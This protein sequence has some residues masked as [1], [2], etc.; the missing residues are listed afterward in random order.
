MNRPFYTQSGMTLIEILIT[1]LVMSVGLLGLAGLQ[2]TAI[3]DGLDVAK[4]SQVT[5]MANEVI[6]RI[7]ATTA[8]DIAFDP[9]GD[10]G[11]NTLSGYPINFTAASCANPATSCSDISGTNATTCTAAEIA[12]Q[13]I[14]EVF[15]GQAAPAG[16]V[17]NSPDSLNLTSISITCDGACRQNT[18]I[19]VT[20]S[21][22]SQN[23][24]DSKL[25]DAAERAAQEDSSITMTVR[26]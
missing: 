21:W 1:L 7:R 20:I 22:V 15:C 19:T 4:R 9:F 26:P 16:V 10:K 17:A 13:D 23:V 24:S 12:V 6:E 2:A 5:W 8:A 3:K 11:T 14:Q 25:L 18:D